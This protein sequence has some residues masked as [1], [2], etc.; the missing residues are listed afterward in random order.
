MKKIFTTLLLTIL[1]VTATQAQWWQGTKK[2]DGNGNVVT[3]TR[4]VADYDAVSL[5]GSMDVILIKG[6]EG[7]LKV[8]AEEN[9][10]QHITTEVNNGKL[11]ISVEK[12][13]NLNPSRNNDIIITVPFTDIDAVSL[14]GSGDIRSSDMITSRD[15][16]LSVTGSGNVR[17]PLKAESASA[18]ITG[19]GDIDLSG[20]STDFNCKVTGS[21]DISAFDFK[22]QHVKATVTGSGDIQV[23][24][25]E[26]LKASTP[27]SGDIE[28]RGNPKK[29][30]F[31]TMGSGSISKN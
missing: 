11:K 9:L 6:Q 1:S 31:R 26:S 28:Y 22:A 29:E 13:Y 23:Y 20:S 21:G 8:E 27:G 12:G 10:Q 7:N 25:S 3:Q 2:V 5:T 19:S 4:K 30:D 17:L 18:S 15:F 16:S 24:A 14:T